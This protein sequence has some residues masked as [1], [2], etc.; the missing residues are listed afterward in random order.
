MSSRCRMNQAD[1]H[2]ARIPHADAAFRRYATIVYLQLFQTLD[3]S[4]QVMLVPVA[5]QDRA[6]RSLDNILKGIE[7][8]VMDMGHFSLIGINCTVCHLAEL[9]GK[10]C[11]ISCCD[12]VLILVGKNQVSLQLVIFLL[13]LLVHVH[14]VSGRDKFRHLQMVHRLQ[15][16][17]NIRDPVVDLLL[18]IGE[19]LIGINNLAVCAVRLEVRIPI[20]RNEST[21]ALSHIQTLEF[22]KKIH[23]TVG[24]RSTCQPDDSLYLGAHFHESPE[25][26]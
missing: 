26:F 16:Y 17:R 3:D 12:V 20:L 8:A 4:L 21:E 7:L 15:A 1:L 13:L 5:N 6:L 23:H 25:T 18:G 9:P 22:C 19:E 24:T 10:G 2:F 11:G 14:R